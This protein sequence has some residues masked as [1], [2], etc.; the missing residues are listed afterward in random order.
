MASAQP[1]ISPALQAAVPLRPYQRAWFLDRSRRK[2]ACKS[3]RIGFTFGSTLEIADDCADRRTKWLIVSRT[4]DTVKEAIIECANHLAAMQLAERRFKGHGERFDIEEELLDCFFNG[5]QVR[6]LQITLPNRSTIA[7]VTAAP[8]ALRGF[9]GNVLLDEFGFH[10]NS[11]ALWKAAAAATILG[12]RLI[13]VSTPN[14]QQGKYY[15]LCRKAGLADGVAP[16]KRQNG[17]WSAHWV[18]VYTAVAQGFPVTVEDCRDIADDEDTFLQEYCCQF[19]SD[20]ENFIGFE[21]ITAAESWE[22]SLECDLTATNG[23]L[24]AG[25]DIA[26]R[27]DLTVIWVAELVGDVLVT[28]AVITMA[29]KTFAEQ[30]ERICSV[31]EARNLAG[32]PAVLH[33][34][35]DATGIGAPLAEAAAQRFPGRVDEVVFNLQTKEAMAISLKRRYEERKVRNPESPQIRRSINAVKKF[36]TPAGNIRFDAQRTDAGHADE[37]WAQALCNNAATQ[38][39]PARVQ[40]LIVIGTPLT[41][42]LKEVQF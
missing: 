11:H 19:L 18:D 20:G 30:W 26:R 9:G 12:H 1:K 21:L 8:D 34:S 40:D 6:K 32:Q 37:F 27:R 17:I 36:V 38:P 35:I 23:P 10:K 33:M 39:P 31:M 25:V 13:V 16:Q 24:Y 3:R 42:G 28:R 14:Y 41:A 22:A 7:G 29:R 15:A 5:V 2:I 4:Q